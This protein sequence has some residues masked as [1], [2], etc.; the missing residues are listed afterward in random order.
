VKISSKHTHTTKSAEALSLLRP[1][2]GTKEKFIE[3][4][5]NGLNVAEASK[6]HVDQIEMSDV[7]NLEQVLANALVNPKLR[8]VHH[9]YSCWRESNLGSRCGASLYQVLGIKL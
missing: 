7:D 8:T 3:Y 6:S 5:S 9:W 2:D 4:F 1:H